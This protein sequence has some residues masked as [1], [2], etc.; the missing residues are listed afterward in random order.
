MRM[1]AGGLLEVVA[2]HRRR[3]MRE[4]W[5]MVAVVLVFG[6]FIAGAAWLAWFAPCRS[7]GWLPVT[8]VPFRCMRGLAR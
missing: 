3:A 2:A 4:T 5:Y 6:A 7:L 8:E 1:D